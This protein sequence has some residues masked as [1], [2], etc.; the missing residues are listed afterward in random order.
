VRKIYGINVKMA[1]AG[2]GNVWNGVI[3]AYG[4]E[5]AIIEIGQRKREQVIY[6]TL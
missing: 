6:S 2:T 5:N 4:T 1:E 3:R